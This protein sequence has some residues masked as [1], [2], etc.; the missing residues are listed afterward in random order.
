MIL[1][2]ATFSVDAVHR[3][4]L[5]EILPGFVQASREDEGCLSFAVFESST[6]PN[7]FIVLEEWYDRASLDA[8][9]ASN[10]V[11]VF[12]EAVEAFVVEREP[13]RVYTVDDVIRL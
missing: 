4:D 10:H 13:T 1:L 12:K 6:E 8:H 5:F 7:H 11:Q 3:D 2:K 9:E